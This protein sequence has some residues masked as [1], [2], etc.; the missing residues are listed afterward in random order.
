MLDQPIA[1][2]T[3][4]SL[5]TGFA[6]ATLEPGE[7]TTLEIQFDASAYGTTTGEVAIGSNDSDEH[8]GTVSH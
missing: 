8:G 2:P 3:G 5:P 7:S 6:A 1:L 4:F